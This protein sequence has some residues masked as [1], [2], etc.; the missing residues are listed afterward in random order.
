MRAGTNKK[1]LIGTIIP[2]H[3]ISQGGAKEKKKGNNRINN[4]HR[5]WAAKPT[6]VSRVTAYAALVDTPQDDHK[7]IIQEMCDYD[8]TTRP[9]HTSTRETAR[10]RIKQRWVQP[11]KV[12]DPFGGSGALPFGAAWLGCDSYS[13]DYNPVA[14]LIQ[15]CVLEYPPLYGQALKD[16][17]ARW[18]KQVEDLFRERTA[19]YCPHSS[20]YAYIWC[21]TVRC[22]CGCIMPLIHNYTLSKKRGIHFRPTIHD[23]I[24]S[25][26]IH[27]EGDAP[28]GQVGGKRAVCVRCDRPY[29]NIEIRDMIWDHGSEMM[30]VAVDV[31]KRGKGRQ[32][33]PADESDRILYK[34]CTAEL[35]RH[36]AQYLNKYGVDPIPDMAIPMPDGREYR[37]GG[38]YWKLLTVV[39]FDYTRWSHLFNDRQLLCM[40]ILLDI[41]REIESDIMARHGRQYGTAIMTY[42]GLIMDKVLEKYCRL[43]PWDSEVVRHCFGQQNL[44]NTWVYAEAA[45]ADIWKKSVRSVLGG[46]TAA[47]SNDLASDVRHASATNLPYD[48]EY[49][50]AVCT[51]PPYYDSMQYSS[52]ADFFYVWLK[53]CVG[54]LHPELFR[55]TLTPKKHEVIETKGNIR[56]QSP[57]SVVRDSDGYQI[58]MSQALSEIYRVLKRD[59]ILVLVYAHKTTA[60]WETLIESILNAGFTITAAWP[61]DTESASRMKARSTA[62]LASSIYMVSRKWDREPVAEW[63]TVQLEFREHVCN[64]LDRLLTAGITGSD[65]YI[66][67]IG[68]ALEIFGKYQRI[69]R[70]DGAPITVSIMLDETRN[71]C[72]E[73]IVKTLTKGRGGKTDPITKLYITWRWAYGSQKVNYDDARKMFT[74][75]GLDMTDFE[76]GIIRR[77]GSEVGLLTHGQRDDIRVSSRIDRRLCIDPT[78]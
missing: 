39:T 15:K 26:A 62:S 34:S 32:Y 7:N 25:F 67:A 6:T 23:G 54:H 38:P 18:A 68:S 28:P 52:T 3:K 63:R 49:F 48:N 14:V 30:C 71:L 4:L 36:R 27:H 41:L 45:P 57:D 51:D 21:R 78:L 24:P 37:Q 19:Q 61:V 1:R 50:D 53:R 47:L 5:W 2:I 20:H 31:P 42:L 69:R 29:T 10:K 43:S 66:A 74:G 16:D 33:R 11:P 46:M 40:T 76:G 44:R 64:T 65:F 72:S 35:E 70:T 17:M 73:F 13:M 9:N 56:M 75:V 55:G 77:K 60:G 58:L 8:S 59:G 12:L 22:A